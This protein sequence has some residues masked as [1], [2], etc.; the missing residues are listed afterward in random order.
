MTTSEEAKTMNDQE[1]ND[2][3]IPD[4]E[5]IDRGLLHDA[6]TTAVEGV[7]GGFGTTVGILGAKDVYKKIKGTVGPKQGTVGA[8]KGAVGPKNDNE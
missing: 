1:Q 3:R 5:G 6:A 2:A 8:K 7:A 4:P